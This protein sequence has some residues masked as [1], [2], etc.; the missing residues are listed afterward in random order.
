ME[1]TLDMLTLIAKSSFKNT[2]IGDLLSAF[3]RAQA[4][5]EC[6]PFAEGPAYGQARQARR[7][8]LVPRL[9]LDPAD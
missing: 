6:L 8:V 7:G 4:K 5:P 1:D 2:L 9:W 3:L